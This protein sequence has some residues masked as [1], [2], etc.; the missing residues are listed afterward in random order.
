MRRGWYHA[1]FGSLVPERHE[2]RRKFRNA[3]L[4]F[5]FES[6][7]EDDGL[8]SVQMDL[9]SET[10]SPGGNIEAMAKT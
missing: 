5:G 8:Q 9:E 2:R 3:F 1:Y 6:R 10:T 7:R 4:K